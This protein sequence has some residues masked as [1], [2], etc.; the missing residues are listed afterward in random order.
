M[1][2]KIVLTIVAVIILGGVA[3]YFYSG[4]VEQRFQKIEAPLPEPRASMPEIKAPVPTI[5][6]PSDSEPVRSEKSIAR[7]K[8]AA[9]ANGSS[10]HSASPASVD[11][12]LNTMAQGNIAFN[13]PET[14]NIADTV[15]IELV[16]GLAQSISDLS[17]KIEAAGRIE[18]A[19]IKVANR[20]EARLSGTGFRITAVTP[21]IQAISATDTTR[22]AW[23]VKPTATGAQRLHLTLSAILNVDGASTPRAIRTFDKTIAV[24]VTW[25]Q[26]TERFIGKNW[27]WLWAAILVPIG[28]WIWRRKRRRKPQAV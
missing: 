12:I 9:A 26:L 3:A 19:T 21:E 18:S 1:K 7:K 6:A 25:P 2:S 23:D 16:L 27:Q 11:E 5:K 14:I 28:G 15:P 22:W 10:T 13:A 8:H 4:R 20:M 17:R 24:N